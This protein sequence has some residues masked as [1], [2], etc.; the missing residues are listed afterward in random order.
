MKHK[1]FI[2]QAKKE[3]EKIRKGGSHG[4]YAFW[5]PKLTQA[6]EN[7]REEVKVE[8]KSS[9]DANKI[10]FIEQ[11]GEKIPVPKGNNRDDCIHNLAILEVA[12]KDKEYFL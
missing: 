4:I 12:R 1:E 6:I 11:D 10:V 5:I 8:M 2:E 9:P 7:Y 3:W